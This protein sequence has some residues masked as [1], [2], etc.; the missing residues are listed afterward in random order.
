MFVSVHFVNKGIDQLHLSKVF[1]SDEVVD[2]LAEVLQHSDDIPIV[3]MRLD[4]PI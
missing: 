4:P 3:T 1:K 2:K